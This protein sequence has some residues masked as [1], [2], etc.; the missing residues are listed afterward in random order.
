MASVDNL[1]K[2]TGYTPEA[3]IHTVIEFARDIFS[4]DGPAGETV[5]RLCDEL[6]DRL[7]SKNIQAISYED[8]LR[9]GELES[10]AE[11]RV[12]PGCNAA[13]I[14]DCAPGF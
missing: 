5:H 14:C 11:S 7:E 1:E 8:N 12:C 13:Y 4:R 10:F 6:E 3:R 2:L 9:L